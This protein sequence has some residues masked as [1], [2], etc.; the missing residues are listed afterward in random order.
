MGGYRWVFPQ[1]DLPLLTASCRPFAVGLTTDVAATS[2]IGVRGSSVLHL[3]LQIQLRLQNSLNEGEN[4]LPDGVVL[5]LD[6][7]DPVQNF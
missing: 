1:Q 5:G 6:G 2:V 7:M 4:L 3:R